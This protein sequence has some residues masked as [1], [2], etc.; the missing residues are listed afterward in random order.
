MSY[1]HV[2]M[3]IDSPRY[4]GVQKAVVIALCHHLNAERIKN[5]AD[6]EVYPG[7]KTLC[8][9]TG[10]KKT[11]VQQAIDNLTSDTNP[12]VEILSVGVGS[13]TTHYL[14]HPDRLVVCKTVLGGAGDGKR[15]VRDVP[16]VV[17]ETHP[18]L[19]VKLERSVEEKLQPAGSAAAGAASSIKSLPA[20][21][22]SPNPEDT[23]GTSS[24]NPNQDS[25]LGPGV[26]IQRPD[27][28]HRPQVPP[29]PFVDDEELEALPNVRPLGS[30]SV[31][32][33]DAAELLMFLQPEFPDSHERKIII[34]AT[35]DF[36][37]ENDVDEFLVAHQMV[38]A[39]KK[40]DYW[41]H[42]LT[43]PREF[44]RRYKALAK[45][46]NSFYVQRDPK[47]CPEAVW[48]TL[49][50]LLAYWQKKYEEKQAQEEVVLASINVELDEL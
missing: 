38:W 26:M 24:P 9:E 29:P 3:A 23:S 19:E 15:G 43:D 45:Q 12:V 40:S 13:E 50:K 46:Y 33:Y 32:V 34:Q 7:L 21:A 5:N 22:Q 42:E 37:Q 11:A 4:E 49:E 27:A 41:P 20:T 28:S 10:W 14:I 2:A 18:N 25:V 31:V 17:C 48:P 8:M 47:R 44:Y 30:D 16:G 6:F 36:F 35:H 39:Y 1:K